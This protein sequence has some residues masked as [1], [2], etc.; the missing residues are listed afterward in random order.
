MAVLMVCEEISFISIK[1]S[2]G[3]SLTP[4]NTSQLTS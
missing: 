3:T 1:F 2:I 4:N